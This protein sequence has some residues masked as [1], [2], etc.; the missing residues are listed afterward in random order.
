MKYVLSV[1]PSALS[2]AV[3]VPV[4]A[5]ASSSPVPVISPLILATTYLWFDYSH[6]A[7]QDVVYS[8]LVTL[9]VFSLFNLQK[10]GFNGLSSTWETS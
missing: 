9:G 6:L 3:I 8:C 2:V 7:T 1:N 4:I 5:T 10:R